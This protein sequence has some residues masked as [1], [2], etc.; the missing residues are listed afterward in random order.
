MIFKLILPKSDS[1][2]DYLNRRDEKS[3]FDARVELA[4][5]HE[6]EDYK[7]TAEQNIELLTKLREKNED[8]D[9]VIDVFPIILFL[10]YLNTQE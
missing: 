9:T 8:K 2:V 4:K 1:I 6:I 5:E 7:G 3:D 10:N